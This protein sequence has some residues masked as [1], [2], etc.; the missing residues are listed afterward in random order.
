MTQRT[1][2]RI[3]I[4]IALIA[5]GGAHAPV[6]TGQVGPETLGAN[7]RVTETPSRDPKAPTEALAQRFPAAAF[8]HSATLS[9]ASTKERKA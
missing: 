6:E 1:L 5:L 3:L 9:A 4:P 7:P 8:H 2:I